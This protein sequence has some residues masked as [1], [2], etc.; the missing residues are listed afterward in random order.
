[1]ARHVC[2]LLTGALVLW[3]ALPGAADG[4]K[5][6][7]ADERKLD[8][9][10]LQ[11][12][13]ASLL[14]FLRRRTLTDTEREE[15]LVLI[16][17]LGAKAFRVR[18]QAAA[19]LMNRGPVVVELLREHL[20]DADLEVARRAEQCVQRIRDKDYAPDVP[21]AAVR[22]LLQRKPA[23][24][25]EALLAYLPFADS[26]GVADEVRN[27][28]TTLA[29]S[30]GKP[31][32]ILVAALTDKLPVRRAA[33]GEALCRAK[34]ESE[35]PAVLKLLKDADAGVRLRVASALA[36]AEERAAVQELIDLLEPLPAVQAWQAEDIL[37]RLADG[38]NPPT[39]PLGSDAAARKKCRDAWDAWWKEHGKTINLARLREGPRLLGH[40]VIVLLD[41]GR[42]LEVTSAKEV[43]WK[44]DG[45]QFPLDVQYLPNER[46]L[47]AEYHGSR[48]T[49]RDIKTGEIRWQQAVGSGPLVAQRLNNGNTFIATDGQL[50]EVD[51]Q[52]NQVFTFSFPNGQ[53]IMKAMKVPSGEMVVLTSDARVARL[54]ATGK[55]LSG[56]Q[57]DLGT[58]LFGG[59]IHM[60]PNGRVLVPHNAENKVVEYDSAG[61]VVWQVTVDQPIA[62]TRLPNGNTLV[63]SMTLNKAME[64]DASGAEIWS[65]AVPSTRVTR[66]VRRS[67][68]SAQTKKGEDHLGPPPQTVSTFAF[69]THPRRL[70][71][72]PP[73]L[74]TGCRLQTPTCP[75]SRS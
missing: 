49:E 40:T 6:L 46:I 33:A 37:F 25:V 10:G 64:F 55:E 72:S 63:T 53:R 44:V 65:Y 3:S 74:R 30:D 1:M 18:E 56:F 21:A 59:R 9:A 11:H 2:L 41:M 67:P 54:D 31:D 75:V 66:A 35:K 36:H 48:V 12:D 73:F 60:T 5:Q 16:G 17:K 7:A 47:V 4:P 69:L 68:V 42:V 38:K 13:G 70:S 28:L 57:V 61:K 8:A 32:K 14:K 45:L 52:G 39:V 34:V 20:K 26:E 71:R 62:A 50:L 24:T 43:R 22:L 51:R 23:G 27:G 58:R 29:V 15:V 19:D